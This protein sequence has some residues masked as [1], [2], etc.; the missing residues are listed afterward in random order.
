MGNLLV[1]ENQDFGRIRSVIIDGEPWFVGKDVAEAL[2]YSKSRNAIASHVDIEDKKDAPIQGDL[3]GKQIMTIINES[4]MYSL[5]LSSKLPSAKRFKRWVT[6]E[7]LPALRKTGNY[8]T[9]EKQDSYTIEDPAARARRWAEEYEEKVVLIKKNNELINENE[10]MKPKAEFY[11]QVSNTTD[12]ISVGKLAALLK[13]NGLK[14]SQN[15]LFEYLRQ[16]KYLCSAFHVW[17][18]PSQEMLDKG[19]MDYKMFTKKRSQGYKHYVDV[20]SF[21][22]QIT[23]TGQQFL[24]QSVMND[25]EMIK[26][27][28]VN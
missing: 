6:S 15:I 18:K 5:I 8:N 2:G 26:N 14:I 25:Q 23:G 28:S 24:F 9:N 16:K 19:Y 11:D 22:P 7:V 10:F 27:I 1:F 21:T 3:G 12:L 13:K 17:N 20:L 4:G